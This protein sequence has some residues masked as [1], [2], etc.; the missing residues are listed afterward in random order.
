MASSVHVIKSSKHTPISRFLPLP[1]ILLLAFAL[2]LFRLDFQELRGD[3]AFGYFFSLRAYDD[4]IASTLS[5]HEPHP[6]GSYFLQHIWLG[7]AGHSEFALRF[8]SV[9]FGVLTVALLYRLARRLELTL[10]TASV[11]ALLLAVSPYAIWHSQDARMYS[12]LLAL[13]LASTWLMAEALQRGRWQV[14]FLYVAVSWLALH[15]HYFA[16]FVLAA[17]NCFVIGRALLMPRVRFSAAQWVQ[18]QFVLGFFYLPWFFTASETLTG[19]GGNGDSPGF[20]AMAQR[21]LAVFAAGESIPT[22][23][24]TPAAIGAGLLVLLGGVHLWRE[25][26]GPRRTLF[27][28]LLLWAVPVLATWVSSQSRPIFNER[29]LIAAA[30]AFYLLLA[31]SITYPFRHSQFTI[32]NSPLRQAQETA[33]TISFLFALLLIPLLSVSLSNHFFNP[34]YSKTRGWREL[35]GAFE[36]FSAGLPTQQVRLAQNFPDPTIWYY[37]TGPLEHIVL[38]PAA[39]DAEGATEVVAQLIADGVTR[40]ILPVQP[41][42]W[43]DNA[44]IGPTAMAQAFAL[45]AQL[46][47]GVWPLQIYSRSSNK[48]DPVAADF[49]NGLRLSGVALE[50]DLFVPGGLLV[51]Y[52][53]WDTEA[54]QLRGNETLFLHLLDSAGQIVGQSDVPFP[55]DGGPAESAAYGILLPDIPSVGPYRLIGGLYDPSLP[56]APRIGTTD[57]ADFVELGV[58]KGKP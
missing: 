41:A 22:D 38:P 49:A 11:G 26:G 28:L 31:A 44:N 40:V 19:Y 29:Y 9:W 24:R 33:F 35:A 30:P 18:W 39:N 37:Y 17:Q 58:L 34:A 52:L 45:T 47:V 13:T 36:R 56:G 46:P 12:I 23:W 1:A 8:V 16:I 10:A 6:V 14:W 42:D 20:W 7:W 51:V 32:R 3:E 2:R 4:I 27:L 50:P 48:Y 57:G 25:G 15:T 43:W 54:S 21:S 53:R 55:S 5:L